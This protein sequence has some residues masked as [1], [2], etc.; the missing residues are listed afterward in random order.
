MARQRRL[1]EQR[2][3][4]EELANFRRDTRKKRFDISQELRQELST[5]LHDL[6][7]THVDTLETRIKLANSF[8]DQGRTDEAE[9]QLR[10]VLQAQE[11]DLGSEDLRTLRTMRDLITLLDDQGRT[12]DAEELM[13]RMMRCEPAS[14]T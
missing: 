13:S 7:P 12:N 9:A 3:V 4:A 11:D 1:S 6:G 8:R 5:K 14:A 2:R 10:E